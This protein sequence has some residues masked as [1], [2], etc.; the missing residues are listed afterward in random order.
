MDKLKIRRK[1]SPPKGDM[2]RVDG[3]KKSNKGYL[4]Q[5]KNKVDGSTMTEVSLQFGDFNNGKPIPALVPTLTKQEIQ[6]LQ[7]MKIKGNAH[8]IPQSI[9]R[10]AVEHAQIRLQNGL[11]PFYQDG[12]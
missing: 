7:N 9:K 3:S 6:Q 12:E 2:D 11:N 1:D 4:G 5:I 10:K 8:K